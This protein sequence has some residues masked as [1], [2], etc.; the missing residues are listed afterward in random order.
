MFQFLLIILIIAIVLL[1][2]FWIK[3]KVKKCGFPLVKARLIKQVNKNK[4]KNKILE[5]F[6]TRDKINNT[7][8]ENLLSVSDATSTRYLEELE[9][10]GKIAQHGKIGRGVFYTQIN[11]SN[12]Y[13]SH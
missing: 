3:N 9:K 2:Y 6:K 8:V 12:S 1:G 10:E 5:L 11:G 4:A 7:D 13:L